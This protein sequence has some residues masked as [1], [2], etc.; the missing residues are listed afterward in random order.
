[1]QVTYHPLAE[2]E[3]T[4]AAEFY[5]SRLSGLGRAFRAE[6]DVAIESI[7]ADP[8]RLPLFDEETRMYLMKRF[9]FGVYYRIEKYTVR[10]LAIKHHR[11]R[12]DAWRG[13]H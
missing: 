11:R 2:S 4:Q 7:L 13:R 9:P 12:P 8:H 6:V 10:V 5:E 1:M 3:A